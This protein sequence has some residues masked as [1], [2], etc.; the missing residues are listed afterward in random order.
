MSL[1]PEERARATR[2][3]WSTRIVAA[4][5]IWL[6]LLATPMVLT[7]SDHDRSAAELRTAHA[8][9]D[10]TATL[11]QQQVAQL[12]DLDAKLDH[13]ER[14]LKLLESAAARA[15]DER[16][17]AEADLAQLVPA[18]ERATQQL[19]QTSALAEHQVLASINLRTCSQGT[20]DALAILVAGD[21]R[22]SLERLRGV[23]DACRYAQLA[24]TD[25]DIAFPWDFADP[26]VL[27]ADGTYYA[28]ATNSVGGHTQAIRSP[29]RQA[30]TWVG[31]AL[32]ALPSWAEPGQTWAP[33]AIQLGDRYALYFSARQRGSQVKCI[34]VAFSDTPAGPFGASPSE[35]LMCQAD[36]M[37]SIDPSPFVDLDGVAH[38]VWKSDGDFHRNAPAK[39]WS[40]PL[41]EDGAMV[42]FFPSELLVADRD[43]EDFTIEGPNMVRVADAWYLL[44]SANRWE[45]T[46]YR[47]DYARC[48]TPAGPCHK[49][50]HNTIL[51]SYDATMGPGGGEV[52]RD[53]DG[54]LQLAY[55]AW[56]DPDV[57]FPNNRYLHFG[58]FRV[59]PDGRPV[60]DR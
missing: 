50:A 14:T 40:A 55:H 3:R 52:F 37:G 39:L 13:L 9:E 42:A 21:R 44:Y 32:P 46:E 24:M 54:T 43:D 36:E 49:P 57:A 7:K 19:T 27:L 1:S 18:V 12:T 22:G 8:A 33:S 20:T 35:P 10:R 53:Q 15:T 41:S 25:G 6:V 28:Y 45:T 59:E 38:L 5:A 11:Q 60:V 2:R 47:M 58:R 17:S 51:S 30:W 23:V 56:L 26:S 29:D 48:D 34:G 4:S 31:E 16:A